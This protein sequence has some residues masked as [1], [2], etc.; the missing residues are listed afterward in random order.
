MGKRLDYDGHTA[1]DISIL[2]LGIGTDEPF[3]G[4][5]RALTLFLDDPREE[6]E[7]RLIGVGCKS[8]IVKPRRMF[9][10][11]RPR[12]VPCSSNAALSLVVI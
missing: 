4:F 10:R 12:N 5:G 11:L 9:A 6:L 7:V 1:T 2:Q 3:E 8:D